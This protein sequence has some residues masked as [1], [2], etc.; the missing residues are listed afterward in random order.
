MY[1]YST[2]LPND[3]MSITL[4][5]HSLPDVHR[6]IFEF[7]R[8]IALNEEGAMLADYIHEANIIDVD[9]DRYFDEMYNWELTNEEKKQATEHINELIDESSSRYAWLASLDWL[10]GYD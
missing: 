9:D 5:K 3:K 7:H 8:K 10:V 2:G 4:L 6:I 1:V